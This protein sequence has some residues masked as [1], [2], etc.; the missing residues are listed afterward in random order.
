MGVI[1]TQYIGAFQVMLRICHWN[2]SRRVVRYYVTPF[3]K[4]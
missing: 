2:V 1:V 3:R 4:D